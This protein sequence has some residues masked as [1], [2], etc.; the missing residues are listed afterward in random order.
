M[1]SKTT[2]TLS[3]LWVEF[4]EVSQRVEEVAQMKV[5]IVVEG[6]TVVHPEAKLAVRG[7]QKQASPHTVVVELP[8]VWQRV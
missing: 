3:P 4:D 7:P 2:V 5:V 6:E 8:H 1:S